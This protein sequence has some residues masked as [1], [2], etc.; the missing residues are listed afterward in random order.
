MPIVIGVVVY[1]RV[2]VWGGWVSGGGDDYLQCGSLPAMW[3]FTRNV[4]Y[5]QCGAQLS[6]DL[7][8][9]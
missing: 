2:H 8:P 7:V 6:V 3:F 4:I 5:L 9:Y 1:Q